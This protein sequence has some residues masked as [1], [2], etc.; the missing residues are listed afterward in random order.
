MFSILICSRCFRKEELE[1]FKIQNNEKIYL[2]LFFNSKFLFRPSELRMR[3]VMMMDMM[4]LQVRRRE[5]EEGRRRDG[6]TRMRMMNRRRRRRKPT[7][8]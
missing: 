6:M 2:E 4:I 5:E 8:P 7:G 3:G 1:T